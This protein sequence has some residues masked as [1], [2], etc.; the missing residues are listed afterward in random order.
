MLK[1]VEI[2]NFAIIESA[3]FEPGEH[4]TVISGETGAGK[5]LLID[6]LG[7]LIGKRANKEYVREGATFARVEALF[8][9]ENQSSL[10]PLINSYVEENRLILSRDIY[11]EGGSQVRING[12]LS[13]VSL[14]REISQELIG[15]HAQNEQLN[16]FEQEEQRV[17]LDK[18]SG[19]EIENL[20]D[21]WQDLLRERKRVL[22]KIRSYGVSPEEREYR[23]ELLK[24]QIN[25]IEEAELTI[26]EEQD[27]LE[28][29]KLLSAVSRIKKDL[30]ECLQI[31]S[32]NEKYN[33][34]DNL[35]QATQTLDF[36]S[37]H[38][39]NIAD[40]Q[41]KLRSFSYELYDVSQELQDIFQ[42]LDDSPSEIEQINARLDLFSRLKLKYGDTIEDVIDYHKQ[43]TIELQELI[44]SE[45][46]FEKHQEKLLENEQ[47]LN[48]VSN[49]IHSLR[50][51][52]GKKLAKEITQA[53]HQL[54][55][56]DVRFS[57]SVT[58]IE[59]NNKGFYGKYGRDKIDFLIQPNPGEP[60][61]PLR[62]IASGGEVSRILLAI[63][64]IFGENDKLSVL[65][66][67]EIDAGISGKTANQV[68]KMLRNLAS[69]KQVLCVSHMPQ[70]TAAADNHYLI[71]KYVEKERTKTSLKL[72]NKAD[73]TTE[74][75]RLLSGKEQDENSLILAKQLLQSFDS[76]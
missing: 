27:L 35:N 51:K 5:S 22:E 76:N 30:F 3:V 60:L 20:L 57:V 40:L 48:K 65:I 29:N 73:R 43:A 19:S 58:P 71:E 42:H 63:K 9:F 34:L 13:S 46:S 11:S 36:S 68:A 25:E 74:I 10:S 18:Y 72:L 21:D 17:L 33:V 54:A 7:I 53:L 24:Y 56:P 44:D 75:A 50:K 69:N 23:L 6:A 66:F 67:D 1:K 16:L 41:A 12:R 15:L 59:K 2:Q 28:R 8:E 61:M 37:T 14:L 64:S 39:K 4:F 38:S 26:G 55:M 49:N 70:V 52:S 32:Q 62:K 47:E 45:N 31:L